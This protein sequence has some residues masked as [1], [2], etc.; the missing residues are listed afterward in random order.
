MQIEICAGARIQI[1]EADLAFVRRKRWIIHSNGRVVEYRYRP[2]GGRGNGSSLARYLLGFS[3][4]DGNQISMRNGDFTD[5]RRGN[6][7]VN[8]SQIDPFEQPDVFPPKLELSGE[9]YEPRQ[10]EP[11]EHCQVLIGG[12]TYSEAVRHCN[13]KSAGVFELLGGDRTQGISITKMRLCEEHLE[14]QKVEERRVKCES[15]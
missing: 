10:F 5:V 1:D 13:A 15:I 14:A 12:E 3:S 8:K 7:I 6:L 11:G 9:P 2:G 4:G